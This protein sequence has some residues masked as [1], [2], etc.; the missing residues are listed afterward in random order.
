MEADCA[1]L[2]RFGEGRFCVCVINEIQCLLNGLADGFLILITDLAAELFFVI[3]LVALCSPQRE[4]GEMLKICCACLSCDRR[5][6]RV[7]KK[8]E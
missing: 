6:D 2:A 1:R 3:N 7:R 5:R 4:Q 8:E